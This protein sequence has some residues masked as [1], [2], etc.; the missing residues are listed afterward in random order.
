MT[1]SPEARD[2][3]R[4]PVL[5]NVPIAAVTSSAMVGDRECI[6]RAGCVGYIEKPIDPEPF[7]AEVERCLSLGGEP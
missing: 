6:L 1:R 5:E 3:R 4:N 2:L 7:V